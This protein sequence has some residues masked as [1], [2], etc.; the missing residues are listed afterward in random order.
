VLLSCIIFSAL[1]THAQPG[2]QNY[3]STNGN[4]LIDKRGQT[5]YLSGINWF[6]FETG[7]MFPH[8]IWTRDMKSVLKQV[9][10][11]GFNTIRIPWCNQMLNPG[12]TIK[13]DSY[14][15]D[16]YSGVSPMNAVE[17]T[18]TKPIELLDIIVDWC[19]ANN[20]KIVLDNH[21]KKTDGFL[22]EG[23]WYTD[24]YDENRWI[25]DWVFLANRY[26]GKSALIGCDLKNEPHKSTWG[27]TNPLTDF[28]KAAERC[29]NAILQANPELLIFVEG[30][31]EYNGENTWWGGQLKGAK[32]FPVQLSNNKKLV[33]S[34]HEYGPEVFVQSWFNNPTF[35]NN[36]NAI[37]YNNFDYLYQNNTAPL[38]VGEFGIK[39]QNAAGGKA[40]TWFKTFMAFIGGKYSWTYWSLNPNSG[41]TGGILTDDWTTINQWKMDVLKPYL[42]PMIPNVVNTGSNQAPIASF[43]TDKTSGVAP[44]TIKF[45][46]SNSYD[47]EGGVLTYTWDFGDNSTGIGKIM[48]HTYTSTGLFR[49]TLT[50]KDPQ[51]ATNNSF[52]DI[53]VS[54]I[55]NTS[56]ITATAGPNGI[57]SPSG[58]ISV[59]NG[60]NKTFIITPNS[61]YQIN[62][63]LVNGTSVGAVATYTFSNVTANQT[64]SVSFKIITSGGNC[65]LT[66]FGVPRATALPDANNLSYKKVYTI[67]QNPPN[68]SNVT[69]AVINWSLSNNGL[70]QL[71]FNTNNGV[72][73]WWLDMRTSVQNFAQSQPA[74]TF[75]GT[76]ITNLDGN[77]YY[78]NYVDVNNIV[79]VEVTGKHAFYFSNSTIPPA[80]CS[81]VIEKSINHNV[82]HDIIKT[83]PNPV[84]DFLQ[85]FIDPQTKINQIII[86]DVSGRTVWQENVDVDFTKNTLNLNKLS[87]G[88]YKLVLKSDQEIF[89]KTILKE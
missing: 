63:V 84:H 87:S 54:T 62:D 73:T 19:Q 12:S 45:D 32:D 57:I 48:S 75:S 3:L 50:V 86:Y 74:I 83:Y 78:V 72:P 41:D 28:N 22:N 36:M 53:N 13:I 42:Q 21:S 47:P 40:L 76:G 82:N 2:V 35:P 37:W 4:K 85:V 65:L 51:N 69:N 11:L 79:F 68:L 14:G 30:V 60:T 6:G 24:G 7:N 15:T 39:D 5:V 59:V 1:L 58:A 8:G 80:G 23:L 17:A 44:L 34:P 46:A 61:G 18:K 43:T 56:T 88:L 52:V 9:K 89:S 71:S 33:Y 20:I 10:D 29:G 38:F 49:A 67:G 26:K 55:T 64:I 27:N 25:S 31:A 81:N 66:R 16:P 77:K 70:W